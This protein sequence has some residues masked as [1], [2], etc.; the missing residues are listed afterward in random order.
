MWSSSVVS[1]WWAD[2]HT[3][4][5]ALD[6]PLHRRYLA[7]RLRRDRAATCYRVQVALSS[8]QLGRWRDLRSACHDAGARATR[9]GDRV[10]LGAVAGRPDQRV[11]VSLA[12]PLLPGIC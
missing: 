1:S 6:S 2:D 12:D 7:Y 9:I 11:L 10:L 8:L 4:V 5:F 3:A